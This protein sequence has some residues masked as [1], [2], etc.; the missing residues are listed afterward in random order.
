VTKLPEGLGIGLLS[1]DTELDFSF[2]DL[3]FTKQR[4]VNPVRIDPERRAKF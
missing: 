4:N 3:A 1:L 2:Y